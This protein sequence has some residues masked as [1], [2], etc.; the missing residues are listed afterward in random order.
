MTWRGSATTQDKFFAG[1][2]Y[3]IPLLDS[4]PFG[5][6]FLQDFLGINAISLLG[7]PLV[8]LYYAPFVPLI[9]FFAVLLLVV[10]NENISHFV[11]FN[12]MQAILISI[13][14][15]LFGIVWRYFLGPILGGSLL[16]STLFNTIFLGTIAAVGYSVFQSAMGRYA[17]IP[18]ISNA[19]YSQVR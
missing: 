12:A 8:Q 2:V 4:L 16:T 15:M 11:R 9:V 14:L 18:T 3:L 13:V 1:L 10:R 7:L 5:L 17:E 19:A 6:N